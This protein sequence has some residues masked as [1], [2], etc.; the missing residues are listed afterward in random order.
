MVNM[1]ADIVWT[2]WHN[3][4]N[5][6]IIKG[7]ALH[8]HSASELPDVTCHMGSLSVTCHP[9]SVRIINISLPIIIKNSDTMFYGLNHSQAGQFSIY[10]PRRD[11]RLSWPRWLVTHQ[12]GLPVSRQQTATQPSSNQ[13]RYTAVKWHS[14]VNHISQVLG[15]RR[16]FA[17]YLTLC[18]TL[19]TPFVYLDNDGSSVLQ[20]I[21]SKI[22]T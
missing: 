12:D 18:Y 14:A 15:Q 19:V 13:A 10:L 4:T 8:H 7:A 16:D 21:L 17:G 11:V 9:M 22:T 3:D 5:K 2:T 1:W 20:P 6:L